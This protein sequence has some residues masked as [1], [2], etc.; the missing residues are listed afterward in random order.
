MLLSL[1]LRDMGPFC[2]P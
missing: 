2:P 1:T